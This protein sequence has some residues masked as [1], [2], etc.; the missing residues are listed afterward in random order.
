M[1]FAD[2]G[3]NWGVSCG[4]VPI[5]NLNDE[6]VDFEYADGDMRRAR[7]PPRAGAGKIYFFVM[8]LH[9]DFLTCDLDCATT[10]GR[11]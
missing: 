3:V 4:A 9:N 1:N 8:P 6:T 11:Q 5:S 7:M 10:A 2:R